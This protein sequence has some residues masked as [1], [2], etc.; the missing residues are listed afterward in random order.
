[1]FK[2]PVV[3]AIAAALAVVSSAINRA[4]AM[5]IGDP[6]G[7]RI[8]IDHLKIIDRAQYTWRGRQYCWY[9]NG[10]NGAWLVSVRPCLATWV[11]LGWALR[12]ARLGRPWSRPSLGRPWSRCV[13]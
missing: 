3:I 11:W 8:S 6:S 5:P 7:V 12:L 13:A 1:M 10:W 2:T 9:D 4:D